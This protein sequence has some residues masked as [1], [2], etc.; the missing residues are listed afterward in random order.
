MVT[1]AYPQ[2]ELDTVPCTATAWVPKVVRVRAVKLDVPRPGHRLDGMQC[3]VLSLGT[4]PVRA[5]FT[6]AA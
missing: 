4:A 2:H 6:T 5:L 1:S 3:N